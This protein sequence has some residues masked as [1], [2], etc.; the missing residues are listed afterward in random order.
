[1]IE[2]VTDCSAPEVEAQ[3]AY[4]SGT[5]V[6]G[7]AGLLRA[8]RC[9]LRKGV[10]RSLGFL[11]SLKTEF[12]QLGPHEP[13]TDQGE[14]KFRVREVLPVLRENPECGGDLLRAIEALRAKD[15]REIEYNV[16]VMRVGADLVIKDGNKRTIDFS[17]RHKGGPDLIE[18]PVFLVELTGP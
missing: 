18:Y 8:G 1:M 14:Q 13:P 4:L 17:E 10:V 7:I 16:T 11:S 5:P 3:I 15:E 2:D 12:G 9:R 6:R